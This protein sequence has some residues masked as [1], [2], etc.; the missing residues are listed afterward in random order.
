MSRTAETE[1]AQLPSSNSAVCA[2]SLH[3]L[4][5]LPHRSPLHFT[6]FFSLLHLLAVPCRRYIF[7]FSFVLICRL[8]HCDS[9]AV[10]VVLAAAAADDAAAAAAAADFAGAAAAASTAAA[11]AMLLLLLLLT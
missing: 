9:I 2:A 7:S 8:I 11:A 5:L 1:H 4:V 3:R 10:V 6:L